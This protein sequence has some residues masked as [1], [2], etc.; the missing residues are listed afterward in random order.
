M[1]PASKITKFAEGS[2]A[3][4]KSTAVLVQTYPQAMHFF[5]DPEYRSTR[6]FADS[7]N[8]AVDSHRG[9]TAKFDE[10]AANDALH[11][12]IAFLSVHLN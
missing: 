1:T 10:A 9:I 8:S 12:V 7:Y 11:R 3:L 4:S 6:V 2:A 5:V